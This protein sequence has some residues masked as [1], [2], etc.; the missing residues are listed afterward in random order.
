MGGK[1]GNSNSGKLQIK[2]TFSKTSLELLKRGPYL[3]KRGCV[4]KQKCWLVMPSLNLGYISV[5]FRHSPREY[6]ASTRNVK[7]RILFPSPHWTWYRQYLCCQKTQLPRNQ[8]GEDN[9]TSVVYSDE[10]RSLPAYVVFIFWF[11]KVWLCKIFFRL[12]ISRWASSTM[13]ALLR[14]FSMGFS[15]VETLK[16][17][18]EISL[19]ISTLH[20]WLV[21]KRFHWINKTNKNLDQ[22]DK[23]NRRLQ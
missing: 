20:S 11:E 10:P 16:T 18:S 4:S 1:W 12:I 3:H 17:S 22:I 15:T 9:I 7:F 8:S 6:R 5:P 13:I 14:A 21:F 19:N 23:L 2:T